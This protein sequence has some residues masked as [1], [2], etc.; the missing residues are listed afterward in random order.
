MS[1]DIQ[2]DV[3]LAEKYSSPERFEHPIGRMNYET[4]LKE[5]GDVKGKTVL[6][7][8]CGSGH[9][10]R[11]LAE[12]G[13]IVTGVDISPD[14]IAL[15]VAEEE[16]NPLGI[17]YVTAD[18]ATLDLKKT[19]DLV[20]PSYL[21]HY[22]KDKKELANFA[23]A[24]ARHLGSGGRMVALHANSDPIVPLLPHGQHSSEWLDEPYK[25]GSRVL[26]HLY[27]L[28]GNTVLD[29]TFYYWSVETYRSILESAGLQDIRWV[30]IEMSDDAKQ[31]LPNWQQLD[32]YNTSCVLT[33]RK[34]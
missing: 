19:F 24:I 25:E 13:A 18:A 11:L 23:T 21:L 4:W 15:A 1:Q 12:R 29:I 2:Y 22:A 14:M 27:D 28:A 9:S 30:K 10:S 31:T 32:Q 34:G 8:A 5:L 16:K 6:D 26:L 17:E 7:L 33:A 20:T 3:S